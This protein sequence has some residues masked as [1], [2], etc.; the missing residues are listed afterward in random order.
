MFIEKSDVGNDLSHLRQTLPGPSTTRHQKLWM[1]GMTMVV[2]LKWRCIPRQESSHMWMLS[3]C[4]YM[5]KWL[6]KSLPRQP[7]QT[8]I[9][10]QPLRYSRTQ[11][12]R[13]LLWRPPK[14]SP[15]LAGIQAIRPMQALRP[16]VPQKVRAPILRILRHLVPRKFPLQDL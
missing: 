15:L 9:G 13:S 14:L 4:D 1:G 6:M 7:F 11:S 8:A 2:M 3:K 5:K 16:L 12:K 10:P